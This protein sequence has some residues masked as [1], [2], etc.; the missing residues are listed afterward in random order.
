[1]Y[2]EVIY[3]ESGAESK[4]SLYAKFLQA[5]SSNLKKSLQSGYCIIARYRRICAEISQCYVNVNV[6]MIWHDS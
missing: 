1:M 2:L 3:N 6:A 4:L 5:V